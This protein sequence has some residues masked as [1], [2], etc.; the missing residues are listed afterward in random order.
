MAFAFVGRRISKS[1]EDYLEILYREG[2]TDNI[3]HW[4]ELAVDTGYQAAVSSYGAYIS[5]TPDKLDYPLNLVKGYA[6]FSL[7]E[8]EE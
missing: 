3:Y 6:L 8:A 5:H 7:M 1:H 4:L 2:D